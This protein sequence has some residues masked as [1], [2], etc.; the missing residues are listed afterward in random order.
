MEITNN[1]NLPQPF[2]DAVSS[3]IRV[4][5]RGVISCTGI[6]DPPQK[7]IL[8]IDHWDEIEEDASD[9]VWALFGSSVHAVLEK[10]EGNNLSEETLSHEVDGWNITGTIDLW[11]NG[12]LDD[13][14]VTSVYAFLLG[15]KEEWKWQTNIY[16]WLYRK[17]G[18]EVKKLRIIAILRDWSRR[19]A[20][21]DK[22]YPQSNVL[23]K[24][25][26]LLSDEE[27]ESYVKTRLTMHKMAE[28]G[29]LP[30]CSD[31]ER[32]HRPDT[33]AVK[34]E[35]NKKATRVFEKEFQAETFV[36]DQEKSPP[37]GKVVK[38]VIEHRRGEDVRCDSYCSAAPWCEQRKKEVA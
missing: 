10:H 16:A 30:E 13:Y 37:K 18:F 28:E 32:W 36:I 15:E 29:A 35:G 2:V 4:P 27:V 12:T 7:R 5:K 38:W 21:Q 11:E 1:Q 8:T 9:R 17:Y 19:K 33:W 34:K 20:E 26:E 6:I 25:I 31:E 14:K 23:V 3:S 24:E 22:D